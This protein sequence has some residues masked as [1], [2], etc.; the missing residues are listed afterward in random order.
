MF[1]GDS[2]SSDGFWAASDTPSSQLPL[3]IALP[4]TTTTGGLN[5]VGM[6]ATELNTSLTFA[7]DYAVYGASTDT[8]LVRGST[9]DL[10]DQVTEFS[11]YTANSSDVAWTATNTM[12]V[13]WIGINDVGNSYW[14]GNTTPIEKIHDEYFAKLQI[15]YDAG[16]RMFTLFTIPR[17]FQRPMFGLLS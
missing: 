11:T 16:V 6:T 15:L 3:G 5:W 1:S 14:D 13:F 2:Y 17:K 9:P 8:S 10:V 4:G 7:L 12:A